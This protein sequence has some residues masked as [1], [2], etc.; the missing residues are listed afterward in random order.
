MEPPIKDPHKRG[1][2]LHMSLEY[3]ILYLLE[4]D[5][6]S[7]V[8]EMADLEVQLYMFNARNYT[9][10]ILVVASDPS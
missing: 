10:A 3:Y 6:L 4:E 5:D 1:Q 7:I 8:N 9:S 2:P